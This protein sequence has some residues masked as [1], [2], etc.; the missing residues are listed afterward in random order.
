VKFATNPHDTQASLVPEGVTFLARHTY[1]VGKLAL[2]RDEPLV[3]PED[4]GKMW[5]FA[6]PAWG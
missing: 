5:T 3:F 6:P 2:N 4:L 1:H